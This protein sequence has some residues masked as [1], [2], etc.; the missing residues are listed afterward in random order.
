M[1][2]TISSKFEY[3]ATPIGELAI[4][5]NDAGLL[6]VTIA[7]NPVTQHGGNQKTNRR[8]S[9]PYHAAFSAYF[10]GD[11]HALAEIPTVFRGTAFQNQVWAGLRTIPPGETLSYAALARRIGRPNSARAVGSANGKN[12]LCIV[13]PC[14][15]VIGADGSLAGFSAGPEKKRWLLQHEGAAF[16]DT[17]T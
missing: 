14:H 17:T 10:A 4:E 7:G 1:P 2:N 3:F 5:W 9:S 13:V 11:I 15:R 16:R 8:V 6:A 12:P